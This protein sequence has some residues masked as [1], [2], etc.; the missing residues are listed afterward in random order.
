MLR[1]AGAE[2]EAASQLESMLAEAM[3]TVAGSLGPLA[4]SV[5]VSA[6]EMEERRR[7]EPGGL[8]G[9]AVCIYQ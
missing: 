5:V 1:V 6:G 3:L 4:S 8:V 7:P 2:D 9:P